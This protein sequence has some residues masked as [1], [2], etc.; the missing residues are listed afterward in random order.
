MDRTSVEIYANG[1]QLYLSDPHNSIDH[2]KQLELY[3]LWGGIHL[4]KIEIYELKSIWR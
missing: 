4:S 3:S 1:G 2:P